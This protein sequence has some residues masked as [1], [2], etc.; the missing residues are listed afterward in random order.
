MIP[1]IAAEIA[2]TIICDFKNICLFP[3]SFKGVG[4]VHA[5]TEEP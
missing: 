2:Q 5:C 3:L 4:G 1:N